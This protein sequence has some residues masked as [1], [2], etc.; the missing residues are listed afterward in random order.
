MGGNA[1]GV[2][3]ADCLPAMGPLK[4][5]LEAWL[6]DAKSLWNTLVL[7]KDKSSLRR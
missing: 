6:P 2:G 4:C 5:T 1:N 7:V 3:N